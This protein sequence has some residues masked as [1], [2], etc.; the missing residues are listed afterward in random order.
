M[1]ILEGGWG[2]G[3]GE[4]GEGGGGCIS[5]LVIEIGNCDYVKVL[6]MCLMIV[7][8]GTLLKKEVSKS[9]RIW[10]LP[11]SVTL[12]IK[13]DRLR[14]TV[15]FTSSQI[16]IENRITYYNLSV[17]DVSS[18]FLEVALDQEK[19]KPRLESRNHDVRFVIDFNVTYL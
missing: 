14:M 9:G 12:R 15:L 7:L 19:D 10:H 2:E 13:S 16:T 11:F 8:Y 4:R 17:C 3:C 1:L 6:Q 18:K 5:Y